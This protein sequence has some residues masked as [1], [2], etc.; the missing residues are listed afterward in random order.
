MQLKTYRR[1]RNVGAVVD[2]QPLRDG[3][4]GPSWFTPAVG[5]RLIDGDP[6]L[7]LAAHTSATTSMPPNPCLREFSN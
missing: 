5:N 1:I 4:C 7:K 3:L 6:R 2:A